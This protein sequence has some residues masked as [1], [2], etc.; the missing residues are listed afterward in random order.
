MFGYP[1]TGDWVRLKRTTPTTLTDHLTG[2]GL[3]AGSLAVVT[4]RS[5]RSLEVEVDAGWGSTR[6]SV[7]ANDVRLVRRGGGREAFARRVHHLTVMR[8][9]LALFLSWPVIQFTG[10]YLWEYRTFDGL[11]TAL[12]IGVVEGALEQIEELI[13]DP[14]RGLLLLVLFAVFGRIAYGPSRSR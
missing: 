6:A 10:W 4:S 2:D 9:S 13:V 1:E 5:G 11:T 8:I 3:P 12:A 7:R 14:V